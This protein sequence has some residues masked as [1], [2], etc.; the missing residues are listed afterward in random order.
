MIYTHREGI[1]TMIPK[2]G[3]PPDDIKAWRP[4]T[5]LNTDFKIISSAIAARL[6]LVLGKIIDECQTAYIKG[7]YI[8]ENTRL[9][10]DVIHNLTDG[11]KDGSVMSADFEAAFASLSWDFVLKVMKCCNFGIQFRNL[12]SNIYMS[13]DNFSRIMMNGYL[14][15]KI[16]LSCGI[17]QG[18]PASGYLFNLAVNV[19]ANQIKQSHELTGIR[20][21]DRQEVRIMQYADDTVLFLNG[22]S[23]SVRGALAELGSFSKFSGLNLNIEKNVM[24]PHWFSGTAVPFR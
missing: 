21:S 8:G 15:K 18:D 7:R 23:S 6:K 2:V 4:I 3:K 19:L 20:V 22:E 5:L 24:P 12:I 10:F 14:G 16:F 13:E 9:V 11:K 17:R 1:I